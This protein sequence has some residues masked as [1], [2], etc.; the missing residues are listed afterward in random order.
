MDI[1]N[2]LNRLKASSYDFVI[3]EGV[4]SVFTGLL[5]EKI[6]YSGGEIAISSNIPM[7]LVSGVNK[8]G[9][10]SAA[11]DLVSHAKTLKN[12]GVAVN[13]IILN[14]VYDMKIFEEVASYISKETELAIDNV[15]AIGKIKLDERSSTPEVEIKLEEFSQAALNTVEKYLDL[16]KIVKMADIPHFKGYLSFEEIKNFF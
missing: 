16:E 3:V 2:I 7:I 4:M 13:G 10:E 9:I 15:L 12:M 14:K 8:G 6:P 11:I 1:E 5:N